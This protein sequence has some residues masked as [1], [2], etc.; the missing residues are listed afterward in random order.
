MKYRLQRYRVVKELEFILTIDK[1]CEWLKAELER[2]QLYEDKTA[3]VRAQQSV[4][5]SCI[6]LKS[7]V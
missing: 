7:T 2:L 4:W 3:N 1:S 6:L 5:N